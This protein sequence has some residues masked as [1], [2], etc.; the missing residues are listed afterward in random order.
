[1]TEDLPTLRDVPVALL[2]YGAVGSAVD[3]HL[4]QHQ[5]AI[6]RQTRM[7]LRV[8]HALVRDPDKERPHAAPP[9]ILTADF[10]VIRDDPQ[11]TVV[12]EVMGGLDP[13]QGYI[14]ALLAA[15][16]RLT[17][18]NKQ[19]LARDDNDLVG[20]LL[21][22]GSVCGAIPVL[23]ILRVG[24]PAGSIT[25]ISGVV[26]GTTNFML[27]RIEKGASPQAALAEAQR[28]G[29][30]EADPSEDLS[31]ADAAAK[32][33]IIATAAFGKKVSLPQVAYEGINHVGSDEV[34]RARARGRALRLIGSATPTRVEV[35]LTEL[36]AGH[37]LAMLGGAD[38]AVAI[39]GAGFRQVVLSGP[40]AGGAETAAAVVA[41]L[42]KLAR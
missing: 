23:E 32:M 41:D 30:A 3:R 40:G 15:G 16:K 25:R 37:P 29:F 38:N 39:E 12:A 20:R 9:G 6:A 18:A 13:T 21:A 27:E 1:M 2:G 34:R 36:A 5:D 28:L 14:E 24:L 4:R 33:A 7:R 31:G 22:G 17:T 10:A 11:V 26:N 19:L 42:L 35:R 8:V